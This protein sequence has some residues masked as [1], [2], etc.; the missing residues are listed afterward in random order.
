MYQRVEGIGV[1]WEAV[2]QITH[3]VV[4]ILECF[5]S[6]EDMRYF[7]LNVVDSFVIG[8]SVRILS[9]GVEPLVLSLQEFND[10]RN[11]LRLGIILMWACQSLPPWVNQWLQLILLLVGLDDEA[12]LI[13][14]RWLDSEEGLD[15]LGVKVVEGVAIELDSWVLLL[16]GLLYLELL[17]LHLLGFTLFLLLFLLLLFLLGNFGLL[18]PLL[19]QIDFLEGNQPIIVMLYLEGNSEGFVLRILRLRYKISNMLV[20]ANYTRLVL[21]Q[22]LD[23]FLAC[24]FDCL[25]GRYF[26]SCLVDE[27]ALLLRIFGCI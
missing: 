5:I 11:L 21:N 6:F 22:D 10:L 3:L 17:F 27:L 16:L 19:Y 1:G 25:A 15:L 12:I 23:S 2:V 18:E 14:H 24:E 20:E 4:E 8:S 7:T 13:H 9:I 26:C